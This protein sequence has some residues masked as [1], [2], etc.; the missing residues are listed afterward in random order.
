MIFKKQKLFKFLIILKSIAM[1]GTFLLSMNHTVF[2][3]TV[4][5]AKTGVSNKQ[6]YN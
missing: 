5:M 4:H 1:I 3:V 6:R 2:L